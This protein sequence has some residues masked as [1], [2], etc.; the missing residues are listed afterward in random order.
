MIFLKN[1]FNYSTKI[2]SKKGSKILKSVI[3]FKTDFR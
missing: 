3:A 1:K 2:D